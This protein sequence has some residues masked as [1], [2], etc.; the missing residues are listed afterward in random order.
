[1][2]Q[3]CTCVPGSFFGIVDIEVVKPVFAQ[4]IPRGR[5]HDDAAV[6]ER[7]EVMLNAAISERILDAMLLRLAG[8]VR[9]RDVE[10]AG[11]RSKA[12]H[13][14]AQGDRAAAEIAHHPGSGGGLHHL[15]VARCRPGVAALAWH[16]AQ[17]A[18]PAKEGT[19]AAFAHA[20]AHQQISIIRSR[21]I[22]LQWGYFTTCGGRF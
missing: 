19:P 6:G 12:V 7:G 8:E 4:H 15:A 17:A 10:G 13:A 11:L 22:S 21:T 2:F 18:A 20:I 1:L 16:F 5:Q 14:A 9:F 3:I